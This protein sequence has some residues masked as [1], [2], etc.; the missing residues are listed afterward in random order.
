MLAPSVSPLAAKYPTQSCWKW[1]SSEA[2]VENSPPPQLIET[3]PRPPVAR[4]WLVA[5]STAANKST[6]LLVAA[7]TRTI[8]ALGAMAC[9]HSMS[10]AASCDQPQFTAGFEPLAKT[11]FEHPFAAED[12][13]SPHLGAKNVM[14]IFH[15]GELNVSPMCTRPTAPGDTRPYNP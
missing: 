13:G 15:A 9:A 5:T 7:S 8:F 11:F 12:A 3:P 14:S 4:T 6:K 1:E 10:S 2:S